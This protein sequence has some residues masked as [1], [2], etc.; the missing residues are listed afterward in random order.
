MYR[1]IGPSEVGQSRLYISILCL[2]YCP[3]KTPWSRIN[4]E[5]CS[6]RGMNA[7]VEQEAGQSKPP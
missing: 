2:R 1:D 3:D 4:V 5:S 6:V 7:C